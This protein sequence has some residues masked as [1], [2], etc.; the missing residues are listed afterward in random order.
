MSEN[1]ID[2]RKTKD[3]LNM[4]LYRMYNNFVALTDVLRVCEESVCSFL[5]ALS[6]SKEKKDKT[7]KEVKENDKSEN[8]NDDFFGKYSQF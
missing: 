8:T 5:H 4:A 6:D 3:T 1:V 2:E 7:D